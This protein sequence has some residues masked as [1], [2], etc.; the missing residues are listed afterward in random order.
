MSSFIENVSKPLVHVVAGILGTEPK[1]VQGQDNIS[2]EYYKQELLNKLMGKLR[3]TGIPEYWDMGFMLEILLLHGYFAIL[4][5]EELGEI[6]LNASVSGQNWCYR[7]TR[8]LFANPQLPGVR[9]RMIYNNI[10][11]NPKAKELAGK[12]TSKWCALI[13][14]TWNRRS[15]LD[16]LERYAYLLAQC[17]ASLA[18]NLMN[19]KTTLIYGAA[20]KKEADEYK[21]VNDQ[22]N[23]G[24]PAVFV[25]SALLQGKNGGLF[26]TNP[27]KQ[28][29]I[30][31]DIMDLKRSI[32]NEFLT[33][34]GVNNANTDKKE[35]LNS[36][37]V[38]ANN[39]EISLIVNQWIKQVNE[40]LD[41]ANALFG[42]NVRF[43]LIR[44]ETDNE[45][46]SN[47]DGDTDSDSNNSMG[48][49][50]DK[51][52]TEDAS[53]SKNNK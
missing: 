45:D 46:S 22:I 38:N 34:I 43:E 25:S 13:R 33:E 6:P 47:S 23:S 1:N 9:E 12:D 28:N 10:Y 32:T 15:V 40:D 7:P 51:K 36:D 19:T 2:V 42:L 16:K 44:E 11:K 26:V 8:A 37:E 52:N 53:K 4:K 30:G 18:V 20:N 5:T 27:A 31:A 29:F 49:S 41:V 21:A 39:G 50:R 48:V 35:R 14:L 17:D 24:A 3:F